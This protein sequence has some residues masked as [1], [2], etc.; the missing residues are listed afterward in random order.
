MYFRPFIRGRHNYF[1]LNLRGRAPPDLRRQ[2]HEGSPPCSPRPQS[3]ME[4][5][6]QKSGK[7]IT[8]WWRLVDEIYH[9]L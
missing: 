3:L 4:S 9:Y 8:S 6:N 5:S 7:A 1:T 2:S